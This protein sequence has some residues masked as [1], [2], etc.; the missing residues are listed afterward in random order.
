[1]NFHRMTKVPKFHDVT[2]WCRHAMMYVPDGREEKSTLVCKIAIPFASLDAA[3]VYM[4]RA[5]SGPHASR[6][7]TTYGPESLSGRIKIDKGPVARLSTCAF[8]CSP[9]P[10]VTGTEK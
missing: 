10:R 9:S 4:R 2:P 1:M 6:I 8:G 7:S 3:P 5:F